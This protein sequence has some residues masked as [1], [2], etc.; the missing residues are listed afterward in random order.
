MRTANL[1]GTATDRSGLSPEAVAHAAAQPRHQAHHGARSEPGEV[2]DNRLIAR[3]P[4]EERTQLLDLCEMVTVLPGEVLCETGAPFTQVYF[5]LDCVISLLTQVEDHLSLETGMVG[6][7]GMLGAQLAL[8]VSVAPLTARVIGAGLA[9]RLP[10]AALRRELQR[11]RS[12]QT[13]LFRYLYVLSSQL[14]TGAACLRFHQISPRL[15]RRLLMNQDRAHS[16]RF[17]V[18]HEFL[19]DMLGVRRVGITTAASAMQR[20]GLIEYRRGKLTVRDRAG[21]QAAAC[22]CYAADRHIYDLFL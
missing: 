6:D 19:A 8:G 9:W 10:A 13:V 3:L 1:D 2:I 5:P 7:E 4:R 18:T 20:Q 16:D 21:L 14:A 17:Q 15:A 12:L 11:N 22:S